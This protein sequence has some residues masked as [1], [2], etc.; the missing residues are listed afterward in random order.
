MKKRTIQLD[1][2]SNPSTG[3]DR[4]RWIVHGGTE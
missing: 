4:G 2:R 1:K 3:A